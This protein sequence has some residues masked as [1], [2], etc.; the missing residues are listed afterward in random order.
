MGPG[1]ATLPDARRI[2]MDRSFIRSLTWTGGMKWTT[3]FLTWVGT[4]IV[5]RFLF[6]EDYGL[7][8]MAM[9]YLGVVRLLSEFSLG[10]TVVTLR[11]LSSREIKQLNS[12]AMV[13]G[14]MGFLISILAAYPVAIFFEEPRLRLVVQVLSLGFILSSAGIIPRGLLERDLRFKALA[15]I[16]GFQAVVLTVLLILLAW[17]GLGYWTL[18]VGN[19]LAPS[20]STLMV[21]FLR[22]TGLDWPRIKEMKESLTF[23]RHQVTGNLSWYVYSNADRLVAG[24]ALGATPLGIYSLAWMLAQSVPEKIVGLVMRVTPAYF[25]AIQDDLVELR[26]YFLKLTEVL[27]MISFPALF[28]LALVA[29][30]LVQV[31]L[32]E[33]WAGMETPLQILAAYAAYSSVTQLMSRIL[34]VRRETR[35]LMRI[36]IL[37]ALSMPFA[38]WYGSQWGP[39]GIA[40]TWLTIHPISRVPMVLRVSRVAELPVLRYLSAFV[41]AAVSTAV[42]VVPVW[43]VGKLL[44]DASPKLQLL[45]MVAIGVVAY[46]ATLALLFGGRVRPLL[47][48]LRAEISG[49]RISAA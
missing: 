47:R 12:V 8:G 36:G 48:L 18:V 32:G 5:A 38:F 28:G 4:L 44:S 49:P 24:K 14:M 40:L 31:V 29:G 3:Q 25:S 23:T 39:T 1:P 30:P 13:M 7:I 37:L 43:G 20:I 15:L 42:M 6:P 41:P 16:D 27:A 34:T 10:I 46:F 11:E 17:W 45:L 19:L 35:F 26:R 9:V 2:E 33:K 22:P 21:L